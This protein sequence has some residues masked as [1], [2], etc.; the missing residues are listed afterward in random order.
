DIAPSEKE[1]H[2]YARRSRRTKQ[3]LSGCARIRVQLV[4]RVIEP[5]IEAHVRA[6]YPTQAEIHHLVRR[7]HG[8]RCINLIGEPAAAN[9]HHAPGFPSWPWIPEYD[10]VRALFRNVKWTPARQLHDGG[11]NYRAEIVEPGL[12]HRPV[13]VEPQL[14][15]CDGQRTLDAVRRL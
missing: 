2:G 15:G 11:A 8:R 12:Q 1:V 6:C 3:P 10:D 4:E 5:G 14:A 9:A 13:D 7:H